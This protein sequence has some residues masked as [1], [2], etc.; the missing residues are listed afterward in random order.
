MIINK[1]VREQEFKSGD[2]MRVDGNATFS[3]IEHKNA[4]HDAS[5]RLSMQNNGPRSST[6][7]LSNIVFAAF[8]MFSISRVEGVTAVDGGRT[9]FGTFHCP[10]RG[11]N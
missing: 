2:L 6:F 1:A 10:R 5:R 7:A 3:T 9:N 11:A 8:L 4:T